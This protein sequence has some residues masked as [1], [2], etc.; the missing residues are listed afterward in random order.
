MAFFSGV[1]KNEETS[2]PQILFV[3]ARGHLTAIFLKDLSIITKLKDLD[4]TGICC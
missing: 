2:F 4:S 3:G 1:D